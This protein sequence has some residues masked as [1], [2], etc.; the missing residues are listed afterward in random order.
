MDQNKVYRDTDQLY[1]ILFDGVLF[2][3]EGKW[4]CQYS[5]NLAILIANQY[6]QGPLGYLLS[7]H[8][9]GDHAQVAVEGDALLLENGLPAGHQPMAELLVERPRVGEEGT[10]QDGVS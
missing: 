8:Q 5:K 4:K 1:L 2:T 9:H 3:I 10:G 7:I 6:L